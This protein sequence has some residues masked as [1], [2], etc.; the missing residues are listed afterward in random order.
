MGV[1]LV[2]LKRDLRLNDHRP[3]LEAARR[4]SVCVLYLYEPDLWSRPP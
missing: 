2:W 3:L 4:G 1:H